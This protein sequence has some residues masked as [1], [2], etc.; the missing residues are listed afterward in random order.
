MLLSSFNEAR[1]CIV[2][3]LFGDC[4]NLAGT[5]GKLG[6]FWIYYVGKSEKLQ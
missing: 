6:T 3:D 1:Q 4:D 2:T 5:L